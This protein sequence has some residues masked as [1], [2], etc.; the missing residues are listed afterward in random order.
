[1]IRNLISSLQL[2]YGVC[3][4]DLDGDGELELFVC[5]FGFQNQLL[6]VNLLII[7]HAEKIMYSCQRIYSTGHELGL[8]R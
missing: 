1:M 7:S 3:V 6:K 8:A 5:G 4:A 2:N